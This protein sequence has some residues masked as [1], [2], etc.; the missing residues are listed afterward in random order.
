MILRHFGED[1]SHL[2]VKSNCCDNCDKS[3]KIKMQRDMEKPIES[4][5]KKKKNKKTKQEMVVNT[6]DL[7][8]EIQT[9]LKNSSLEE[10]NVL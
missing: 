4:K 9:A 6:I 5:K 1:V 8:A 3:V 2:E 7:D 10:V